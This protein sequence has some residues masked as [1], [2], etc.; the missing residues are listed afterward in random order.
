MGRFIIRRVLWIVP[1]LFVLCSLVFLVSKLTN[2]D[3]VES[4]LAS[5]GISFQTN[6]NYQEIY[7]KEYIKQHNDL[8]LYYLSIAPDHY[9]T[10]L[11]SIPDENQKAFIKRLL[12]G[13]YDDH[14]IDQYRLFIADIKSDSTLTV[15]NLESYTPENVVLLDTYNKFSQDQKSK[16]DIIITQKSLFHFP[17]FRWHGLQNQFHYWLGNVLAGDWGTSFLDGR[18]VVQ[19]V[20][21]AFNWTFTLMIIN[22]ILLVLIGVPV[23]LFAVYK[24]GLFGQTIEWISM[25]FYIIPIFWLATLIQVFLTTP[26]YGM[27]LFPAYQQ[28]YLSEKS[29]LDILNSFFTQ[30][31]PAVIC[32]LLTDLAVFIRLLKGNIAKEKLLPY[33]ETASAKGLSYWEVLTKHILP[34]TLIPI[35]TILVGSIPAFLAGSLILEVIFNIPGMGRL[36][37]NSITKADWS[38]VYFIVLIIGF[39][40]TIFFLIGDLLYKYFDPK[41]KYD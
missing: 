1:T 29:F 18:P 5:Q 8:P 33:V 13:G 6:A 41:I 19:K 30:Y 32:L 14:A 27:Q 3:A 9:P 24:Q 39:L 20:A 17:D 10:N 21:S 4:L 38:V 2:T 28:D 34:N 16:L 7:T 31:L 26:D 36:L 22:L 40:T 11:H 37:F 12:K 23:V 35:I 25:F 15:F